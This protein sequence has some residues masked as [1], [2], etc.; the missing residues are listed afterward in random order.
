MGWAVAGKGFRD[1]RRSRGPRAV[2]AVSRD[3]GGVSTLGF[4]TL[5]VGAATLL[6]SIA[7]I[8][9][10]AGSIAGEPASGSSKLLLSFPT[11]ART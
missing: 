7:A 6:G 9:I 2:T 3:T 4:L 10:G 5:L 1:A 8:V 11:A